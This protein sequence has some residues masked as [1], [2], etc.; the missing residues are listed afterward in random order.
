MY[1]PIGESAF[2]LPCLRF[3]YFAAG[4]KTLRNAAANLCFPLLVYVYVHSHR[5]IRVLLALL[6]ACIF[7]GREENATHKRIDFAKGE[8]YGTWY[9]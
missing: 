1:T 9:D 2:F 4:K 7:C 8:I 6:A 5:G 3:A